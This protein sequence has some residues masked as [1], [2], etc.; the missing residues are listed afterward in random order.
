M[1]YT[2]Q[3]T[4][5]MVGLGVSAISDAWDAFA[6]NEK[7]VETYQQ[8]VAEGQLPIFRGHLLDRE[9][10]ILRSHILNLMCRFETHWAEDASFTPHLVNA[11]ALLETAEADGLVVRSAAGA[12]ITEAGR[13]FLRNIC[14]AFDARLYRG[15]AGPLRFSQ[16][17]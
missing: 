3:H 10:A 11:L 5:L 14:M 9:D 6:Q 7:T 1:G 4:Q 15:A 2:S 8:R 17:V 13:P 16:S 12:R